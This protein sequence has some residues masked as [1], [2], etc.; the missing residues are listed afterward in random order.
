MKYMS[1]FQ[2]QMISEYY[3][4]S[5][6]L[7]ALEGR[8]RSLL[9]LKVS[10]SNHTT[11]PRQTKYSCI[12]QEAQTN[13]STGRQNK[14][15][16]QALFLKRKQPEAPQIFS[17]HFPYA[18]YMRYLGSVF[19]YQCFKSAFFIVQRNIF[20]KKSIFNKNIFSRA[21]I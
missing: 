7:Y 4:Y 16:F 8:I 14:S 9:C 20:T 6:C 12:L 15:F 11:C 1:W 21:K 19:V 2:E 17:V 5:S 18:V 13:L 10:L 3:C